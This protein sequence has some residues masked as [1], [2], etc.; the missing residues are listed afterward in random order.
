MLPERQVLPPM[1]GE[2]DA[3]VSLPEVASWIAIYEELGTV[4][5]TIVSRL[6]GDVEKVEELERT[7][8]WIELRL[9]DWRDRHATLAGVT[10]D[11][12][13]HTLSYRGRSV[14]LTRREADLLDF[15]LRHPR[16]SFT[17]KQLSTLAW[18]DSQLA[19]AQVRTYMMR[20]RQRL[21]EIGLEDII[22]LVRNR[23]YGAEPPPMVSTT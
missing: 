3:T 17:A 21:R 12:K 8:L 18:Q 7:L 19:D 6:D 13:N 10:I 20:L 23:G 16:R 5:R 14:Q 9:E 4:L 11:R 22:T 1:P 2:D 15:M